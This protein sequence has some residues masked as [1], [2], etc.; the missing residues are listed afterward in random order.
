LV[1]NTPV[2]TLDLA[3]GPQPRRPPHRRQQQGRLQAFIDRHPA[4]GMM[5]LQTLSLLL[6]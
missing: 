4:S 3:K 2:M 1:Y 5:V 6:R